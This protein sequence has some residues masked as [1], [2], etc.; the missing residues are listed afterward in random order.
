MRLETESSRVPFN[1]FAVICKC[2]MEWNLCCAPV[3]SILKQDV[4]VVTN[5]I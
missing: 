3:E 5:N 2:I 4:F 1:R